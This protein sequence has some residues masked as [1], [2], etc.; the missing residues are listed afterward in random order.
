MHCRLWPRSITNLSNP[1]P[2]DL[3]PGV[4]SARMSST[5][6][7]LVSWRIIKDAEDGGGSVSAAPSHT[8]LHCCSPG[9]HWKSLSWKG[10]DGMFQAP[11]VWRS[12]SLN[13]VEKM[14]VW[15]EVEKLHDAIIRLYEEGVVAVFYFWT[16]CKSPGSIHSFW[17][18]QHAKI[19]AWI[20]L[21]W[22]RRTNWD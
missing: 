22:N 14:Y 13:C 17:I 8:L 4:P 5:M 1:S 19:G 20:N 18:S 11:Q 21:T 16:L 7:F 12:L 10:V 6:L 2:K 15:A 9:G 3:H